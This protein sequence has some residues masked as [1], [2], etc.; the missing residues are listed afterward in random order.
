MEHVPYLHLAENWPPA[1]L[2][3]QG[4]MYKSTLKATYDGGPGAR[5]LDMPVTQRLIHLAQKHCTAR[6]A[7]R[8][9]AA[10]RPTDARVRSL[11]APDLEH[12]AECRS[13]ACY[14]ACNRWRGSTGG[15]V[16]EDAV[17]R[18]ATQSDIW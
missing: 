13:W 17:L 2:S 7:A 14:R 9:A 4:R 16:S 1:R 5:D 15:D 6:E 12:E 10:R 3:V 11:C 8:T 18:L